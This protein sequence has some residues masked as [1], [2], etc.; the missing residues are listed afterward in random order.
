MV[1]LF[2]NNSH[3]DVLSQRVACK[4]LHSL[5]PRQSANLKDKGSRWELN[6]RRRSSTDLMLVVVAGWLASFGTAEG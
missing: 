4:N 2:R 3:H 6:G 1:I 5:V